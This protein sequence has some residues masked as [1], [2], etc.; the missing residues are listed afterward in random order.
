MDKTSKLGLNLPDKGFRDWDVPINENFSLIDSKVAG[1]GLNNVFTGINYFTR[2]IKSQS[3]VAIDSTTNV[4]TFE[5]PAEAPTTNKDIG[6]INFF[7]SDYGLSMGHILTYR[8]TANDVRTQ[9]AAR[10]SIDGVQKSSVIEV[11]VSKDGIAYTN[12]PTP[13]DSSNNS[14]IAVTSWV[15]KLF[16]LLTGNNVFTG[17][18][19]FHSVY[20]Y[21]KGKVID[22]TN[23]PTTQA[24]VG[25][26]FQDK[27]GTAIGQ[28]HV[29]TYTNGN[30]SHNMY[31]KN[32]NSNTWAA[33]SIGF[34][35]DGTLFTAAP[36]PATANNSTNIATTAFVKAQIQEVTAA[37]S[38]P[39]SGVLYVIPE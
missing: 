17:T 36:T 24:D 15:R 6:R 29:R 30:I 37:P 7:A 2:T 14:N 38:S 16:A 39:V 8:N 13:G 22:V 25:I 1:L 34:N 11:G 12:A 26:E 5:K 27:N 9:I 4:T 20:T 28:N 32:P 19:T 10:Q 21:L 33:I 18:N 31:V 35:A 23:A 3:A